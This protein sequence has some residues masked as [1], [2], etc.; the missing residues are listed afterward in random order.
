MSDVEACVV[1]TAAPSQEVAQTIARAALEARLAACA[2]IQAIASLYW[3]DGKINADT[4][5]LISFKT[6]AQRYDDLEALIVKLHPYN[7]PEII[8]LPITQGLPKYLAWLAKETGP[9]E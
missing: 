4:E 1:V 7:T 2:H 3:W 9:T 5:Q 6:T 8:R